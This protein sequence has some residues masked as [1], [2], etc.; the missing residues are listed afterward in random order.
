MRGTFM[1]KC[2]FYEKEITPPL[3][4]CIPGYTKRREAVGVTTKLYAKAVAIEADGKCVI[5]IA[6]DMLYLPQA[7][8]DKAVGII[9]NLTG[10]ESRYVM[11]NATHTHTGGPTIKP[12]KYPD[13]N[14]TE[15][16]DYI[17]MLGRLVG[18]C[19]V[20]AYQRLEPMTAKFAQSDLYGVAFVRNYRMKD[21]NIRTNPGFQNPDIVAPMTDID[22][23]FPVFYFY[24]ENGKPCGALINYSLHHCTV[25]LPDDP[26]GDYKYCADYSGVLSDELK[27]DYGEDFVSVFINGTCGNI[28]H[29]DYS[30]TWEEA[31]AIPPYIRIGKIMSERVN[32]M[33]KTAVPFE[34][35]S[36]DGIKENVELRR[37]EI[38]EED[39]AEYK[40][41]I[42]TMP[43]NGAQ[44]SISSPETIE[45]KRSISERMLNYADTPIVQ[46]HAIQALRFGECMLYAVPGEVYND[47]GK[48]MKANSPSKINLLAE[49]ANGGLYCYVPSREMLGYDVYESHI[50]SAPYEEDTGDIMAQFAVELGKRIYNK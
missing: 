37:R 47:Y 41:L 4:C 45:Y 12:A 26:L 48:Y 2:G 24:N 44:R 20:L 34:I 18:D 10:I 46:E 32:Q 35:D 22:P 50:A 33:S 9:E 19:G 25:K 5:M 7:V 1:F 40:R 23:S 15:D 39:I 30:L 31:H 36:V 29:W 6:V 14:F 38:P 8:H 17:D 11:I 43:R 49:L 13:P 16:P 42:E 3:G 28:N 27:K 21:G